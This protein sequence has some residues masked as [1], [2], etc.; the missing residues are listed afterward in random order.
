MPTADRR[1]YTRVSFESTFEVRTAEWSD[2]VATGLD[3]SLNG[4]RFNCEKSM[5]DGETVTLAFEHGFELEGNVRWCWPIE[6]YFQAAVHFAGISQKKQIQLKAYIE[7]VTGEDFQMELKDEA[8]PETIAEA[9]KSLTVTDDE[10][11]VDDDLGDLVTESVE[12]GDLE[13]EIDED[14][15]AELQ[16]LEE[17]NLLEFG[18]VEQLNSKFPFSEASQ[19]ENFLHKFADDDLSPLSFK[20]KQIVIFDM[21]KEQ[22]DLLNQ[23]LSERTGMVVECV[24]KK[25]NLWRH[26]KIDPLDLVILETGSAGNS[27]ALE[28]MQ[29]TKDQFSEVHFICLSGPVSLERRIQFLNAGALD[30]LTRPVHLSTIAQSILV[31]LSR[32]DFYE[33]EEDITDFDTEAHDIPV[34]EP[35]VDSAETF[36]DED[37]TGT[38]DLLDEDLN[39]LQ[40]IELIDE[41]F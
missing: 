28:V 26:L 4:C 15:L 33:K 16:P 34:E 5:S 38:L 19:H 1:Q 27:D 18:D 14:E 41:D 24:T 17:E 9:E 20:E 21:A 37:L 35:I 12:E 31:Q 36:H 39:L 23:Y 29:Q 3:I 40:E 32:T 8:T 25:Q 6:W 22:A 13:T 30:Y 10:I 7:E 2:P 11:E